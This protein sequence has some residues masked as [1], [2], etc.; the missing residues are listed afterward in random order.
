MS[1]EN[2]RRIVRGAILSGILAACTTVGAAAAHADTTT[3]AGGPASAAVQNAPGRAGL[4]DLGW[5]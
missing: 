3:P 4:D 5:Q 1:F 2:A